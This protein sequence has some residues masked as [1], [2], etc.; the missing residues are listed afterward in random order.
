MLEPTGHRLHPVAG[1]LRWHQGSERSGKKSGE[2]KH[3][4]AMMKDPMSNTNDA[5]GHR[6][7]TSHLRPLLL[8]LLLAAA[9]GS[10]VQTQWNLQALAGLGLEIPIADRLHTTWQDLMGFAPV[11][12]GIVAI[13]WL[14]AL[15]VAALLARWWPAR[16]APLM[17]LAAGVGMVAAVR[18]VDAIAPMPVFIDA[19]RH[20]SGLLAMALG[21]AMAGLL[22]ARL[23]R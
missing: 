8:A 14:P 1:G 15:A 2:V 4:L 23:T 12:A 7:W 21:A 13:G 22:Y 9:W 3:N 6:H 17:T 16:R 10:V 19:T 20:L 11:Y 5:P 18:S